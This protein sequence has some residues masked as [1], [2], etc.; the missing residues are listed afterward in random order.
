MLDPKIIRDDPDFVKR[1]VAAKGHDPA[2]IDTF[3]DLDGEVRR[4]TTEIERLRAERKRVAGIGSEAVALGREI[5]Q[6]LADLEG[7]LAQAEPE[8][9]RLLWQIPNLP[10]PDVPLGTSE[11]DNRVIREVGVKRVFDFVPKPHWELGEALDVIDKERAAKV[12]GA[13]FAYLKGKL[14][15][16]QFALIQHVFA[17]VTNRDTIKEIATRANLDVA[18]TPFI[19]VVPPVMV[20]P[21]AYDRMARLEPRDDRYHIP[22][23]DLYLIGSAEHTLGAMH[24]DEILNEA[25]LPLRYVGYSTAFRREAGTYGKDTKGV[26]RLHQFDK[27][28]FES[29]TAK[30]DAVKEQDFL[31]AIEEYLMQSLAIP[32]QV[33]EKCTADIGDPDARGFDINTWMP[34]QGVFRE[35]HTADLMT[36]YQSRRLKTRVKRLNGDNEYVHMND[37]TAIAIGRTLVAVMENYQ[38]ADGSIRVPA[39]LVPYCGFDAISH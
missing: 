29:F 23:D 5:K 7:Q 14:A 20:K 11:D 32:Y 10:L 16:L 21:E 8:Y 15:L 30:E 34:G 35:T 18:D 37:A 38:Q 24:M 2:I 4:L 39:A 1:G 9:Q 28:E 3:L 26:L 13:R 27:L 17:I 19:P 36:D 22:S 6:Q 33:I 25:D 31:V 12:T